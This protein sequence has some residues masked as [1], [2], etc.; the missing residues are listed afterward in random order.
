MSFNSITWNR[1]PKTEFVVDE[2]LSMGAYDAVL[3]FNEGNADRSL[4]NTVINE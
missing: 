2:S 4:V 3:T 1:A